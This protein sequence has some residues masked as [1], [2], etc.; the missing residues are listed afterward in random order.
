MTAR[1]TKGRTVL[2]VRSYPT[3]LATAA[4]LVSRNSLN[5]ISRAYKQLSDSQKLAWGI[6]A[7]RLNSRTVLG[8]KIKLTP[9]NAFVRLNC[10]RALAG[11]GILMDPPVEKNIPLVRFAAFYVNS[12]E[13]TVEEVQQPDDNYKL[14]V[15]MT[16]AQ[17]AGVSNAWS[18]TVVIS[19][20][21]DADW[22]DLDLTD[23]FAEV[24]GTSPADGM[25]YFVEMY[26]LDAETG[27]TGP[28]RQLSGLAGSE[29]LDGDGS[30]G[31]RRQVKVK[32]YD[33]HTGYNPTY[34]KDIDFEL[35]P[36][37]LL[38]S[39][40]GKF[41]SEDSMA[42]WPAKLDGDVQYKVP[43]FMT[44]AIGR[45]IDIRNSSSQCRLGVLEVYSQV[46]GGWGS[47]PVKYEF[48][49]SRFNVTRVK[50]FEIFDTMAV[51]LK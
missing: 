11:E 10:N 21:E 51:K 49:I 17:S 42:G 28:V 39:L 37:S 22:G 40:K 4:Q 14:V 9:H 48:F 20:A 31:T 19:S 33:Q 13:V 29:S 35:T 30:S 23:A 12:E 41:V 38:G 25:K 36:G 44:Y 5:Q 15:K 50:S 26:W 1:F 7:E 27:F 24:K 16:G 3:G 43:P 47:E 46:Y 32:M 2:S 18:K 6:L 45:E 34:M 8:S